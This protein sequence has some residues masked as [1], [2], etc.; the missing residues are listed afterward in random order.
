LSANYATD[1]PR[2]PDGKVVATR[3][4]RTKVGG[5]RKILSSS[6]LCGAQLDSLPA[7]KPVEGVVTVGSGAKFLEQQVYKKRFTG[8][9]PSYFRFFR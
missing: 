2:P 7:D 1:T 6:R 8:G 5:A 9:W 3:S 4:A